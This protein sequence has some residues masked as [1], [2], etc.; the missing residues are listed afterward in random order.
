MID[1]SVSSKPHRKLDEH[2]G[3]ILNNPHYPL[4]NEHLKTNQDSLISEGDL[5]GVKILTDNISTL[6]L[7]EEKNIE[8]NDGYLQ[9]KNVLNT[10]STNTI[11]QVFY[12]VNRILNLAK[13]SPPDSFLKP[14]YCIKDLIVVIPSYNDELTLGMVVLISLQY[15]MRVIVVDDGSEDRTTEVAKLAGAEVINFSTKKGKVFSIRTGLERAQEIGNKAVVVIEGNGLYNPHEIPY[16]ATLALE[17]E[18]DLIIGSRFLRNPNIISSYLFTGKYPGFI[19]F[20]EN[21]IEKLLNA[22]EIIFESDIAKFFSDQELK[23]AE[24]PITI[25]KKPSSSEKIEKIII[26]MPAYN[27]EKNL[28]RIIKGSLEYSNTVLVVD[29]G[30][31]DNTAIVAEESGAIVIRHEQNQGYGGALRTIFSAARCMDADAL[32]I[33][34]SDGQHNPD[35]IK[36]FIDKLEQGADVVIGSRFLHINNLIPAYRKFGMKILDMFT[37]AA[38]VQRVTDSQSGFRAYSKKAISVLNIC[39]SG[40]SAGSEILIQISENNL[41]VKEVPINVRYDLED[42]STHNPVVHGISVLSNIFGLINYKNPIIIFSIPAGILIILGISTLYK[43]SYIHTYLGIQYLYLQ[44]IGLILLITGIIIGGE[45][46][47]FNYYIN[48]R[49]KRK[50]DFFKD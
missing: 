38:G 9:K 47:L 40:M 8:E 37:N 19:V 49:K 46:F 24:I 3:C 20:S 10:P 44:L 27:E 4:E 17:G 41:N 32:I 16:L 33:I 35:D 34:D 18:A 39:D 6:N 26:A 42:T 22:P 12:C 1:V 29:D 14:D 7:Q 13:N 21:A 48:H 25:R 28:Q 2:Y 45:G 31:S 30:S 15:A 5:S 23:V 43:I 11:P 50:S 36:K